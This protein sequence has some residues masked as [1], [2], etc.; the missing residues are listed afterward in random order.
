MVTTSISRG[1]S[2][3]EV[4][5]AVLLLAIGVVGAGAAQLT[6]LKARHSTGL[7]SSSVQ[8]AGSL[9]DRMR[10]NA[11]QMQAGDAANPYLR[12]RYDANDGAPAAPG[13][14]C[15]AGASCS[16]AQM[17]AFDLYEV[18]QALYE[19][20]PGARIVVCRDDVV[21]DE[22]SRA[23]AWECAGGPGAPIVIKLGWRPRT[24][25]GGRG[26]GGEADAPFAPAVAVVAGGAFE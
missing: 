13:V 8:L 12:L 25:E 22:R 2:L 21:W 18:T 11:A 6:A 19:Q 1:F 10:A 4:L 5:V 7:L 14:A 23:L 3:V 16:S 24:G 17:A 20:Y 9:A 26:R 15:F